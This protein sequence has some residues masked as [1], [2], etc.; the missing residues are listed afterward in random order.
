[1]IFGVGFDRDM[2]VMVQSSCISL[3]CVLGP[4]LWFD[5]RSRVS[6]RGRAH[7]TAQYLPSRAFSACIFFPASVW[8]WRQYLFFSLRLFRSW[9]M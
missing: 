2:L 3:S 7:G 1:M 5:S 4:P 9:L 6:A 8:Y